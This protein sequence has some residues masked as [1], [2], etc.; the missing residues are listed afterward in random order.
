MRLKKLSETRW[1]CQFDSI[2]SIMA[3]F[4]AVLETLEH[5]VNG[6]DRERAI[7]GHGILNGN[8]SFSFIVSLTV[9]KKVFGISAQLSDV[10]QSRSL[11]IGNAATLVLATIDRFQALRTD[12]QWN[13]LWEEV[14]TFS[15]KHNQ[16]LQ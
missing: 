2:S 12:D 13:L 6:D 1:S 11:D 4:S 5:V 3:T 15:Q 9:Y 8:K 14:T 10:L 7:E 16:L